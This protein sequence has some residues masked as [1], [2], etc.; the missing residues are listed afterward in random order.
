[1]SAVARLAERYFAD[2][3]YKLGDMV[4][5][6]SAHS[7]AFHLKVY[8]LDTYEVAWKIRKKLEDMQ[9]S[10]RG[11]LTIIEVDPMVTLASRRGN[12]RYKVIIAGE[13][14]PLLVE[15]GLI[16]KIRGIKKKKKKGDK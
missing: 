15:E 11:F 14:Q 2:P 5:L 6:R 4:E 16:K 10:R 8:S 9:Q 12:K 3:K 7:N 1:M 13:T